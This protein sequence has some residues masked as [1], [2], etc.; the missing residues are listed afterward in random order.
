[1][2]RR[3]APVL[4]LLVA[5]EGHKKDPAGKGGGASDKVASCNMPG[6]SSCRE[7][8]GGNLALGD[9]MLRSLCTETGVGSAQFT[10]SPCPTEK[11]LGTCQKNEG[12]DFFYE[13]YPIA[14]TDAESG[15]KDGGGTFS[16]AR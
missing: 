5:C 8:R 3:L 7:Y 4:F 11:L 14:I 2:I 12:K 15:C 13:G 16:A 1:M 6:L 9:E 10:A